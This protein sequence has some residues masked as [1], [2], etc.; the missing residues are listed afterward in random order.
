L[1]DSFAAVQARLQDPATRKKIAAEAKRSILD[2]GFTR[3]D[4]AY[5]ARCSWDST[6]NGKNI[7]QIN[8]LWK[9]RGT[10]N[11]EIQTVLDMIEK[12]GASMVYHSMSE[13]D[14]R[15]I[16]KY[17][18][19][20]VASDAG[21][22]EYGSGVPHPRGYGTNSRVL[23]E[24]VRN[25]KILKLEDAI[26]KMTSLPAQRFRLTD[27]GLLRPGLWADIV[28]F[29]A[30][31]VKDAATFEKPHAYAEGFHYVLVNGLPVI[32]EGKHNGTRSGQILLGPGVR[33]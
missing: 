6:L 10:L 29:D 25:R 28:I 24:Y 16:M 15:K 12:G 32:E 2:K 27:R 18:Y 17:P 23:G 22:I 9:R 7:T 4:Y 1:A 3:L 5:V 31:K 19:A 8:R 20:M 13:N 14:V 26:R 33:K 11:N 30:A 21:V